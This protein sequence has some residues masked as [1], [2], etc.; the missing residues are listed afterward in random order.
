MTTANTTIA[1]WC[2]WIKIIPIFW[3]DQQKMY[4]LVGHRFLVINLCPMR[5][6]RL[7][8]T[9]LPCLLLFFL[10]NVTPLSLPP[11]FHRHGG[12]RPGLRHLVFVEIQ[13]EQRG[14]QLVYAGPW[15]A[16]GSP[17]G[18]IP[19]PALPWENGHQTVQVTVSGLVFGSLRVWCLRG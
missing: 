1:I 11:G 8:I 12:H 14:L 9:A 19:E 3:S 18:W 10:L 13:L 17:G 7:K 15:G 5:R 16:V 4:F 6:K 2:E